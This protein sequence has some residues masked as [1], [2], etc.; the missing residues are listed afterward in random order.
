[1]DLAAFSLK[2]E[3]SLCMQE[4]FWGLP[5]KELHVTV[6]VRQS[7]L[8]KVLKEW[9][10][11]ASV[12]ANVSRETLQ[13]KESDWRV[14]WFLWCQESPYGQVQATNRRFPECGVWKSTPLATSQS[15]HS[16]THSEEQEELELRDQTRLWGRCGCGQW[17]WTVPAAYEDRQEVTG[18]VAVSIVPAV[19]DSHLKR[20]S[21]CS[22]S[23]SMW[24]ALCM[25]TNCLKTSLPGYFYSYFADGEIEA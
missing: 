19:M 16:G 8:E 3:A 5:L 4:N 14:C 10:V 17:V 7:G 15:R 25:V 12:F 6:Q 20:N 13:G 2:G 18:Q 22:L 24:S 21:Y 9:G 23:K 1:M 11:H